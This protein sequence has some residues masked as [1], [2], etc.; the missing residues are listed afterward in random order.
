MLVLLFVFFR[1]A[2]IEM[3]YPV[4]RA[5]K[6]F[7]ASVGSRIKGVFAASSAMAENVRLKREVASLGMDRNEYQRLID[8][9]ARLRKILG[10]SARGGGKWVAA[11]VLSTGGGAAGAHNLIRAGK[12][13]LAG[14]REGAAVE[15]PEGLVGVVV[16]VTLH[17]CEIMPITDP[18][19]KVSCLVEGGGGVYGILSGGPGDALSLKHMKT[20]DVEPLSRVVTSGL[21]GVFPGGITVGDW[22]GGEDGD[23]DGTRNQ[24][25]EYEGRVRSHVDFQSLESV[26][27]RI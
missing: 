26:F 9:N 27:I 4:E 21:G 22:R 10:F 18:S 12:G 6:S 24:W 1:S 19:V 13:S 20:G 17:T 14:I 23:G 8:E 25:L 2:A 7:S 16:S 11:E 3:A 5:A 15:V